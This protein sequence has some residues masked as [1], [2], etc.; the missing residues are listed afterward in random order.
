[1]GDVHLTLTSKWGF[2][3]SSGHSEYKQKSVE[4]LKD[5]SIVLSCLV[6]LEIST[7]CGLKILKKCLYPLTFLLRRYFFDIVFMSFYLS[8]Q[9]CATAIA[10]DKA[11]VVRNRSRFCFS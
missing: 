3:G 10:N 9:W 4:D 8:G 2:D 6:P 1:V 7:V 5:S 11:V